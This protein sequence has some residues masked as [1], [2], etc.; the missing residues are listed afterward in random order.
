[1]ALVP[2][3]DALPPP[4]RIALDRLTAEIQKLHQEAILAA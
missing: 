4:L 1:M 3:E 2:A